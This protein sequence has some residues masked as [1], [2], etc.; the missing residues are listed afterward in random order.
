MVGEIAATSSLMFY[1]KSTVVVGFFFVRLSLEISSG[2][3]VLRLGTLVPLNIELP[4]KYQLSHN[5]R[6]VV[7]KN[8]L[9][10]ENPMLYRP[11]LHGN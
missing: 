7:F 8:C 6:I 5:E 11:A 9:H 2:K 4:K 1:F 3:E 10:S